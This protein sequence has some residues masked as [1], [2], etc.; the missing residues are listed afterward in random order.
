MLLKNKDTGKHGEELS[1][2]YLKKK[3]FTILAR[4][5]RK[6]YGELDIIATIDKELIFIEVKTRTSNRYGDPAEAVTPSKQ[7]QIIRVAQAYLA[8]NELFDASIRFDVVSVVCAKH[9][10]PII[11][12]I[13]NAFQL[14]NW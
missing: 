2:K 12:H 1:A 5:Y 7:K 14:E 3:K 8:E 11:S 9:T 4:N 13:E 6:K 10:P